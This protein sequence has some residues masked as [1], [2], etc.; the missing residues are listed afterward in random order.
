MTHRGKLILGVI[1]ALALLWTAL[2][3]AIPARG[4]DAK[5]G[6]FWQI[7]NG[8]RSQ[9]GMCVS[10]LKNWGWH[11]TVR[12][13][14]L[15]DILWLEAADPNAVFVVKYPHGQYR[16]YGVLKPEDQADHLDGYDFAIAGGYKHITN[17][18]VPAWA[19]ICTA[20][21]GRCFVYVGSV[22]LH[23]EL[24]SLPPLELKKV[25]ERNLKPLKDAGFAGVFVDNACD[26]IYGPADIEGK[27]F[28][29]HPNGQLLLGIADSYFG[30]ST[31]VE[32]TPRRFDGWRPL[33]SRPT[34]LEERNYQLIHAQANDHWTR[35]GWGKDRS[36][37][38]GRVYRW[39]SQD[40]LPVAEQVAQV[41]GILATQVNGQPAG[42]V[43]LVT[44]EPLR[45]AGVMAKDLLEP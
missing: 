41:K 44:A 3:A 27:P 32:W 19:P 24:R 43:A 12:E 6:A 22:H 5:L 29:P 30:S 23:P 25:I 28:H 1:G 38:K 9:P 11:K 18:F 33:H 10:Y 26:A 2:F 21:P 45:R 40:S 31:G 34:M 4:A 39:V 37:L 17:E 13:I 7:Y 14:C 16:D 20:R 36:Y 15:K 42:D 35:Q 8:D